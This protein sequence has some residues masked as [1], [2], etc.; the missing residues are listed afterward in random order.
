[1]K[2]GFRNFFYWLGWDLIKWAIVLMPPL[3]LPALFIVIRDFIPFESASAA[4]FVILIIASIF[5]ALLSSIRLTLVTP[6]AVIRS[7]PVLK[8]SWNMTRGKW[9]RI[10]GNSWMIYL[11]ILAYQLGLSIAL[12]VLS[13]PAS[14]VLGSVSVPLMKLFS[15]LMLYFYVG[16]M[17]SVPVLVAAFFSCAVYRMLLKEK[18]QTEAGAIAPRG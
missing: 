5:F 12:S 10:F 14:K 7:K 18:E 9:W 13:F 15:I 17:F 4:V 16:L 8:G 1:M 11:I 3:I 6:L 2:L